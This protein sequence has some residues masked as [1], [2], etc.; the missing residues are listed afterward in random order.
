MATTPNISMSP[1]STASYELV[2]SLSESDR[3]EVTSDEEVV[4]LAHSPS[5]SSSG[6]GIISYK[7]EDDFVV[8][9]RPQSPPIRRS[10]HTPPSENSCICKN[11]LSSAVSGMSLGQTYSSHGPTAKAMA[12]RRSSST[13]TVTQT[14]APETLQPSLVGGGLTRLE[15]RKKARKKAP[16]NGG[17]TIWTGS[18][19]AYTFPILND[20]TS[21]VSR[22]EEA[23]SFM[24]S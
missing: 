22:Y 14:L 13:A 18:A 6:R 3:G 5:C 7:D 15:K 12:I 21:A 23:A 2:T 16:K 11:E 1:T 10:L 4:W 19:T 20:S 9:S 24:T 17:K 8:L